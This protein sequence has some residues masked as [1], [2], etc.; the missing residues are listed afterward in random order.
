MAGR[1]FETERRSEEEKETNDERKKASKAPHARTTR[2]HRSQL[3]TSR[4]ICFPMIDRRR[5]PRR[6]AAVF[7]LWE[8]AKATAARSVADKSRPLVRGSRKIQSSGKR[9]RLRHSPPE[10]DSFLL[11]SARDCALAHYAF[12]STYVDCA[13]GGVVIIICSWRRR[14]RETKVTTS[15]P[16]Y[17]SIYYV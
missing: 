14:Q 9:A 12:K 10:Q 17:S 6:A 1:P 2:R 3:S 4:R 16:Y 11:V 5:R 7:T 15:T 13:A 8:A